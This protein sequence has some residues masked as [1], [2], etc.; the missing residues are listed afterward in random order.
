MSVGERRRLVVLSQVKKKAISVAEAA[1]SLGLS[2]RHGRRLWKRYLQQGDKGLIHGLRGQPGNAGHATLRAKVLA[3]YSQ[4][5][6][7]CNAAHAAVLLQS[8]E[9]LAVSRKTLWRWLKSQGWVVQPRRCKPH[10]RRRERRAC[11][12]E[13]VQMDGSTHRWFGQDLPE[14]VLF[15]MIDDATGRVWAR[16]YET[17]DTAAAFDLFGRY[18]RRHGLPGSLYVDHDSI[19]VV[20]ESA[21]QAQRR[22]AAN[23]PALTQFGRAMQ[24]LSVGIIAANS[25]Q[26]KGR[27]ERVNRTLQDRLVKELA[28]AQTPAGRGIRDIPAANRFLEQTFLKAFNREFG[29]IPARG[30]NVHH[31]VPAQVKL[32]EVLCHK[33]SRTLGQDWCV[34]YAGRILQ[35]D[36]RHAALALAGTRIDVLEQP[37]GTLKLLRQGQP[38]AFT[39]VATRP[40]KMPQRKGVPAST[41]ASRTPWRPGPS[42][43]WKR[44]LPAPSE[45]SPAARNAPGAK[46]FGGVVKPVPLRSDSLRS[47]P[48]APQP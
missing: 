26:A 12:G 38:L 15:V 6:A 29:Q 3:V 39:E 34:Q 27:V 47:P 33:E 28:L 25:P 32:A 21:V 18:V 19:Y 40:P 41:L 24:E 44:A 11:T 36:S 8:R 35:I 37:G 1:R 48:C 22:Q 17:E 42:H 2:E 30:I 7:A 20:N 5:Y 13:L 4:K 14:C 43:P 31:K 10:R 16:F 23:K 45:L 46:I 9:K